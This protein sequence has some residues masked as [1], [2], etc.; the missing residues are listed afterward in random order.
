M[1]KKDG[2][3]LFWGHSSHSTTSFCGGR[4]LTRRYAMINR[5]GVGIPII[6]YG[7]SGFT[8]TN[9]ELIS[10]NITTGISLTTPIDKALFNPVLP[11]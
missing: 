7:H 10:D 9:E 6:K 2:M 1:D 8:R 5:S 11:V 4:N 3:I